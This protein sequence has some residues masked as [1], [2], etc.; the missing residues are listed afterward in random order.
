MP[1]EAATNRNCGSCCRSFLSPRS[2]NGWT[3]IQTNHG[4]T[5]TQISKSPSGPSWASYAHENVGMAVR[6]SAIISGKGLISRKLWCR[7]TPSTTGRW[8]RCAPVF[9]GLYKKLPWALFCLNSPG[10]LF[11]IPL[12]HV[13]KEEKA[14]FSSFC[15]DLYSFL[16]YKSGL[17]TL[18]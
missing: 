13:R 3:E 9:R 2:A 6:P 10:N 5:I 18:A 14:V 7:R 12:R 17:V 15:L 11:R 8:G 4:Q 16:W 1:G